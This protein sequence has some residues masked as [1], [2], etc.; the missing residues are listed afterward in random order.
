MASGI[1]AWDK[2][3]RFAHPSLLGSAFA[4][5]GGLSAGAQSPEWVGCNRPA[6]LTSEEYPGYEDMKFIDPC[7]KVTFADGVRDVVLRFDRAEV[8]ERQPPELQLHLQDIYYPLQVTLHYRVHE[9]Y[10]LIELSMR[11][12]L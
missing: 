3:G 2:S 7:L 4:R 5:C 8:N 9:A 12:S 10:D 11:R 1:C 6:Q